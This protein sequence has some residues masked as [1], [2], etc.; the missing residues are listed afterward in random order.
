MKVFG[1]V[2]VDQ[3]NLNTT[4]GEVPPMPRGKGEGADTDEKAAKIRAKELKEGK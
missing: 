2:Q 1:V 4:E 3:N